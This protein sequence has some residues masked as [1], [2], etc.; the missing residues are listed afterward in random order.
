MEWAT[1][2]IHWDLGSN[3]QSC[4]QR[5]WRLDR[6]WN[7]TSRVSKKFKIV[8]LATNH[9]HSVSLRKR[10]DERLLLAQ[11][12]LG[13]PEENWTKYSIN[14]EEAEQT[15]SSGFIFSI[16]GT[17]M[18]QMMNSL[19]HSFEEMN[20][21]IPSATMTD[22]NIIASK[23]AWQILNLCD[24]VNI[25]TEA[26]QE[27]IIKS[28]WDRESYRDEFPAALRLL[29]KEMIKLP[30]HEAR[31][32]NRLLSPSVHWQN[33]PD[34]NNFQ[35]LAIVNSDADCKTRCRSLI[36]HDGMLLKNSLHEQG[37]SNTNYGSNFAINVEKR[38]QFPDLKNGTLYCINYNPMQNSHDKQPGWLA[39]GSL[40]FA[41]NKVDGKAT[42]SLVSPEAENTV[43]AV[44]LIL[45]ECSS[46]IY[47]EAHF[48]QMEV[49][50]NE[51]QIG[52]LKKRVLQ[53]A[54]TGPSKL[55]LRRLK[56]HFNPGKDNTNT[57]SWPEFD[58]K[59]LAV[60]R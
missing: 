17:E 51:K 2:G 1:L 36:H 7:E 31:T 57:A 55:F 52:L 34:W 56:R 12:I 26:L 11:Q 33:E 49:P 30:E 60:I 23:L 24:V 19:G 14:V 20:S 16:T 47:R 22:L 29:R 44:K 40:W 58:V 35:E 42:I 25:D 10:L 50:I 41:E 15:Y 53:K 32:I 46:T 9:P 27:F 6:R 21:M 59:C 13:L 4:E 37:L 39:G 18:R 28:E 38:D 45:S 43:K 3:P 8:R 54:E 5:S 48:P